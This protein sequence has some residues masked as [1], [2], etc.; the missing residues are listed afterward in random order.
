MP[1]LGQIS[2]QRYLLAIVIAAI[3]LILVLP[4]PL[5]IEWNYII[6]PDLANNLLKN[7]KEVFQLYK[8]KLD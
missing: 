6:K 5:Y 1:F 7:K 2:I 4:I 8:G 3:L